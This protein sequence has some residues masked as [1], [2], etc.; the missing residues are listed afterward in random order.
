MVVNDTAVDGEPKSLKR[1]LQP[2]VISVYLVPDKFATRTVVHNVLVFLINFSS[3][4]GSLLIALQ[5][6]PVFFDQDPAFKNG[7]ASII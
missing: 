1:S 5:L 3:S 2:I 7:R 4:I 6:G